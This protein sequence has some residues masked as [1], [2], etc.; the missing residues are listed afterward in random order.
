[1]D[2]ERCC[3]NGCPSIRSDLRY[4]RR[5]S[6]TSGQ[7]LC[8][9]LPHLAQAQSEKMIHQGIAVYVETIF[10]YVGSEGSNVRPVMN[11]QI[12]EFLDDRQIISA[13]RALV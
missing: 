4:S 10:F 8:S 13:E 7:L 6:S 9:I 12:K 2:F 3:V 11:R 5:G 1:M